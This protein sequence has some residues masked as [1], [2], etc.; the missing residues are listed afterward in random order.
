M[1]PDR[2]RRMD[3]LLEAA[4]DLPAERR[5]A[6][7]AE[8][9]GSDE[10]LRHEVERM[11]A[12]SA[13]ADEFFEAAPADA[14]AEIFD[15][16]ASD[17]LAGSSIGPYRI[18]RELGRGGMGVVWL[19]ER[20]DDQ[21]RQ[22]VAIKLLWP[23]MDNAEIVRR[24]RRER[25]ILANLHHPN[26][27]QLYDGGTTEDGRPY[28]V[29]EY[30]AGEPITDYCDKRNLSVTERLKLFQ[31]VC[32]AALYA[33]QNLIIHRDLKP[34]NIM[35]NEAGEVKLL[36]F[37]IAKLLDPARHGLDARPTTQALM[38]TPEYASPEQILGEPIT[39]ASDVYCL[40]LVLY[41]LLTGQP[42]YRFN[43]R[44]L[45]ELVRVVCE[46][47]VAAPSVAVRNR[48]R[49]SVGSPAI[50]RNGLENQDLPAEG[51]T[52]NATTRA[53]TSATT[54]A[55]EMSKLAAQLRGDLD[56]I[57]LMALQKDP[58][59]RYR[60]V[61]QLSE[62][63][64]RHL[65][66]EAITAR[67]ASW[68]YQTNK[69]VRRNKAGVA[70]A[71][72]LLL[73]LLGGVV[74]TARQARI[75]SEQARIN[76]RL[77]Y[78][79][80][81]ALATQAWEMANIERMRE[82]VENYL[83]R[84]GEE[85]L[86]EF[87][88]YYLW[89]LYHHTGELF[90]RKHPKEV[91]AVA[92]AP[93]GKRF[94]TGCDDGKARLWD[95]ATGELLTE[96]SGHQNFIWSV[97]FSPDGKTLATGS[98]DRT[99]KL[100]DVSAGREIATLK[101]HTL[102][103]SVVAFS[104]D[105]KTLATGSRDE[106]VKLWETATGLERF[107]IQTG[108]SWVHSLAFSPSSS[109]D[110]GKLLV[111]QEQERKLKFYD[112]ANGRPIP[113]NFEN[114]DIARAIAVSPDGKKIAASSIHRTVTLWDATTKR[115]LAVLRG[116]TGEVSS[117]AFSPDGQTLATAS[118]DRTVKLWRAA[119]GQETATLKGHLSNVYSIA[120]APDG[121]RLV[122]GAADRTVKLWDV[123]AASE[124][125]VITDVG[126]KVARA[127]IS[128]DSQKI[129]ATGGWE[130]KP[131]LWDA[132]PRRGGLAPGISLGNSTEMYTSVD[133]SLDGKKIATGN[134]DKTAKLWDAVTGRELN[135]FS[136][137]ADDVNAVAISPDG[138]RLA[139]GSVDKTIKLWDVAT[140]RE[141]MTLR[142]HAQL[143][144]ALDFSPDGRL[145]A[146]GSHD[147]TAKLWDV[148]TGRELMTFAGHAN[149]ILTL[150]FSPDGQTLATG[151]ADSLVKLWRVSDGRLLSTIKGHAGHVRALA[152]SPGGKR[153]ATGGSEGMV[154]LW[155]VANGQELIAL[156]GHTDMINSVAF[157]ADG[158]TLVSSAADDSVRLWRAATPAEVVALV[159]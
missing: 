82:L 52:T 100:W 113:V 9:C 125:D 65:A 51:G 134:K 70:L 96:L 129:V 23:G 110:G 142:G 156:R 5:A 30:V 2:W 155:D 94:A 18:L 136:G 35:V 150:A 130:G 86:R 128:P 99:A 10:K 45:P 133:Y 144:A 39:T 54:S 80:Q 25:Q 108:K 58:R 153:L 84:D 14:V 73:A 95:A 132:N 146:T 69:F 59:L 91:W 33:H 124:L 93:D 49:S 85:D 107:T 115:Q 138:Q 47:E 66:G 159:R 7:L 64:R 48:V 27:A 143:S 88:W 140:G 28:F 37:G 22:Q 118:G 103:V 29:M 75:A 105:G 8:S 109:M 68:M 135:V 15:D 83:P 72:A 17:R 12:A 151:S 141:L 19:A 149:P 31:Q 148:A 16:D 120:F 62:D 21:Y 111:G 76:R 3:Q 104:P 106:T 102:R 97:A 101:G 50:R 20:A 126:G 77:A 87:E 116:H 41:E 38:M 81:M 127:A 63:I 56:Q 79:G 114:D 6:F 60:S 46:Q 119:T 26:I 157:S 154:R 98:G 137:H 92:F 24:F 74:A 78:A 55:V 53:I 117:I 131:M 1:T 42:P 34:K 122:T 13:E 89:R 11:L 147:T 44:S 123:E 158:R 145:L 36:D 112:A 139:T 32:A 67:T 71:A 40:G 121:R 61:E 57:T 90:S 43:D 152:F 4:L